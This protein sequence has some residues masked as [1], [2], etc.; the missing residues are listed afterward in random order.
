MLVEKGGNRS[1]GDEQ[2]LDHGSL[3][4]LVLGPLNTLV[5]LTLRRPD[6]TLYSTLVRPLA[7]LLSSLRSTLLSQ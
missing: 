3:S 2:N 7:F 5:E 6:N 4:G 1:D